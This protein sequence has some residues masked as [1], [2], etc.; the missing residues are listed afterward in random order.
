MWYRFV[1]FLVW[2]PDVS[3]QSLRA[4]VL[5]AL[6][7]AI[8]VLPQG[9]AFATIAGMPPQYGLYSAMAP[10]VIAALFGSSRLMTS[11]PTTPAS[12]VLFSSL[13]VL[14]VPG[15]ATFVYFALTL[16]FMVGLIQMAMG[17]A[18]LGYLVDFISDS[19]IVGFSAGAAILILLSQTRDVLGIDLPRGLNVQQ[20]L[21]AI[22][23]H[24]PEINWMSVEVAMVSLGSGLFAKRVFPRVPYMIVAMFTG[25]VLAL[26]LNTYLLGDVELIQLSAVTLPPLS[27][28]G[29]SFTTWQQL[30]PTAFAVT[31][32][33][34]T[35]SISIARSLASR[36]GDRIDT[37]QEF[38]GQ[39]L[40]NV[41]G[42]FLSSYVSTGS[43]NRSSVNYE[44]G[45]R[46]PLANVFTAV[47]LVAL[48][49][50]VGPLLSFMPKAATA[51]VLFLVAIGIIDSAA[52][53]KIFRTSRADSIVLSITFLATVLLT[54]DFA[55]ML[56]VL[57]S[58]VIFLNRSSQPMIHTQMPDPRNPR[59]RFNTDAALPEC[60]QVKIVQIDGALFFGAANHVGE[61]LRILFSRS[62]RQK[63]LLILAR[64]INLIDTVGAEVLAREHRRRRALGGGIYVHQIRDKALK[65]LRSAGVA[66]QIGEENFFVSKGEAVASIFE[67]LDRQV[68]AQCSRRV[69]NECKTLPR[70]QAV[71]SPN[72]THAA[73]DSESES[74]ITRHLREP[75]R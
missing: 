57:V 21:L 53:R 50:A 62:S 28:P 72:V 17:F 33:A 44:A 55:I 36:T 49:F 37:N 47:A 61:Q 51:G 16:T 23:E 8:V 3:R 34:L 19:V 13:A 45:A 4:D 74:T 58:I 35:Q 6:T 48:L 15:S 12:I 24:L 66:A 30:A 73:L 70:Q 46:T 2:W 18:R 54:V 69:F 32:F 20:L 31:F 67:K 14:A 9:V 68:C 1:P 26:G 64:T 25:G 22:Y 7:G 29:F 10:A 59:R 52:I 38:I 65:L 63:H 11:G 71:R 5:A 40:S 75:A 27:A 56:G 42:S 41:L 39:G 60:P 43:F